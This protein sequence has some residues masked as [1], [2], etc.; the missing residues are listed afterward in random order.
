MKIAN[1]LFKIWWGSEEMERSE[2]IW[3]LRILKFYSS[4]F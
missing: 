1:Y 3:G 4:C 2:F